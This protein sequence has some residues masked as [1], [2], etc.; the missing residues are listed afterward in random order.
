MIA[1]LLYCPT[2]PE[3]KLIRSRS[4]ERMTLEMIYQ[5]EDAE[6]IIISHGEKK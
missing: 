6:K 4:Y 5:T 2:N 1:V 3:D